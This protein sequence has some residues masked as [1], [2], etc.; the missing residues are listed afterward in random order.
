MPQESSRNTSDVASQNGST[1]N[2]NEDAERN[3]YNNQLTMSSDNS[4][5]IQSENFSGKKNSSSRM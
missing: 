3:D 4:A 2:L 1:H 5:S